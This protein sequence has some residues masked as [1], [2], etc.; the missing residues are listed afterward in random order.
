MQSLHSIPVLRPSVLE[1]SG[2]QTLVIDRT[3]D[4]ETLELVSPDGVVQLVV[5][6][7]PTGPVLRFDSSLRIQ[8]SGALELDAARV[9]IRGT[10]GVTIESGT[11]VRIVARGDLD[12]EARVQ[13]ITARTGNV[14]LKAN[15]DVKLKGERIRLNC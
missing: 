14:E 5:D 7:T 4:G 2:G 6:V 15:D 9:A 11:D 8:A 12:T 1:L 13:H 10:D 3:A